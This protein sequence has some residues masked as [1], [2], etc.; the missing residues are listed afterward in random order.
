MGLYLI[1][2]STHTI[3][4]N[5]IELHLVHLLQTTIWT[6]IVYN[7][8]GISLEYI[9]LQYCKQLQ[10]VLLRRYRCL[11]RS[12]M[13]SKVSRCS[14]IINKSKSTNRR[15]VS[16]QLRRSITRNHYIPIV[17]TVYLYI[18]PDTPERCVYKSSVHCAFAIIRRI[19]DIA[20][21]CVGAWYVVVLFY[22]PLFYK[23]YVRGE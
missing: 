3:H 1:S 9:N 13:I 11:R 21:Y 23:G 16:W 22:T 6:A 5:C 18:S 14:N 7:H 4:I 10:I 8:F 2:P 12:R 17:V 19:L 15:I 20:C